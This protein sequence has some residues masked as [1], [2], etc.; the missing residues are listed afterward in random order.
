MSGGSCDH[1][2]HEHGRAPVRTAI[3]RLIANGLAPTSRATNG[4]TEN[5]DVPNSAAAVPARSPRS[6]N[7]NADPL[8]CTPPPTNISNPNGTSNATNPA[9]NRTGTSSASAANA[10]SAVL[11]AYI[12]VSPTHRTTVRLTCAP[13]TDMTA[14]AAKHTLNSCGDNENVPCNT[15][16][17]DARRVTPRCS[18]P[19]GR[20]HPV[21][22]MLVLP[23]KALGVDL[24]E[25]FHRVACPLR[26][27]G[28]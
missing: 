6:A 13:T 28:C 9:S 5:D 3:V 12:R 2:G 20:T 11:A 15:K 27:L 14:L 23:V 16:L 4:P 7:A 17:I 18:S 1:R 25:D 8:A 10:V 21:P 19:E 24:V 22:C 26:N